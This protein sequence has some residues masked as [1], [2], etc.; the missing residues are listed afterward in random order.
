M[1]MRRE[2]VGLA[3]HRRGDGGFTRGGGS[4]DGAEWTDL[5]YTGNSSKGPFDGL[6]VGL[7]NQE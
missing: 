6:Q 5:G 2:E 1:R 7:G 4:K 3:V